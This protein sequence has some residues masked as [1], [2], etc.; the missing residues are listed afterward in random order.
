MNSTPVLSPGRKQVAF[1]DDGALV[2]VEALTGK[3]LCRI[4]SERAARSLS[5]SPDGKRVVG[6]SSWSVVSWDL[7]TGQ[8]LPDIGLPVKGMAGDA[9][10]LNGNFVLVGGTDLLD[11]DKKI[12]V[13][14]YNASMGKEAQMHGGLCWRVLTDDHRR[15]I[16]ACA[17]LPHEAARKA[18]GTVALGQGLLLQ[19]GGSVALSVAIDSPAD[20]Q[21]RIVDAM[22]A[23]LKQ[24]GISVD[25][26]SPIK[27]NA[28]T[29]QGK[30]ST[31]TY[32]EIGRP[33]GDTTTVSVT[34]KITRVWLESDG[35]I[36]W[37][38]RTSSGGAPM[39][40]SRKEGQ[41]I[42]AA[43]Q[44]G[45]QFNLAFLESVR[46]PAY[47]PQPSD[48]PWLGESLWGLAGVTKDKLNPDAPRGVAAPAPG[49]PA[50]AEQ[51]PGS[52]GDGL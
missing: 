7:E 25:P 42:N 23:Q 10:A 48:A 49:K 6:I 8:A 50:V 44:A 29:E 47:V 28:R 27:L 41:D 21:K 13:W 31:Q 3:V 37:E 14:R 38:S 35:K 11:L 16:L 12:V 22:T 45:S 51:A 32:R 52:S 33:F 30:T 40:V 24:A 34:E 19:P 9:V 46:V 1:I 20:Q 15:S 18:A 26:N 36:A 17:K 2:V 43:V 39:F 5:Y 4:D